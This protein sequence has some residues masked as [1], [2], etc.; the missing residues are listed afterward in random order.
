MATTVLPAASRLGS[1]VDDDTALFS[2]WFD[3]ALLGFTIVT[4]L[5]QCY[6]IVMAIRYS[7]K[8]MKDYRFV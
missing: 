8:E 1:S 3:W 4:A 5:I 6:V 7:P 2:S